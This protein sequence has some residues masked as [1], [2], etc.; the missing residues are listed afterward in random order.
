MENAAKALQIAGGVLLSIMILGIIVFA[1]NNWKSLGQ[2]E[3]Q[4]EV[5]AQAVDFN[6]Q[7]DMY[8]K[9]GVYGTEILSL[10]N[11]I[12][13][14]NAENSDTDKHFSSSESQKGYST[15]TLQIKIKKLDN[16]QYFNENNNHNYSSVEIGTKYY[17]LIGDIATTGSTKYTCTSGNDKYA[18]GTELKIAQ[19]YKA[20]ITNQAPEDVRN[21]D[22]LK[23]YKNLL[24]EQTDFARKQFNIEEIKYDNTTGRIIELSFKDQEL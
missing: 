18:I 16:A 2:N 20:I 3:H 10:A 13:N 23:K 12:N 17:N 15:I 4:L 21:N 22:N 24:N 11:K 19:W 14:Y 9:N 6:K 7:F 1:Y 5:E 8:M